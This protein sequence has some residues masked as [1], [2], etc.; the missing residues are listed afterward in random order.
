MY[1]RKEMLFYS[2]LAIGL[3]FVIMMMLGF[4]ELR[5]RRVWQ[6]KVSLIDD[7]DHR[8]KSNQRG[9]NSDG[10]RCNKDPDAFAPEHLNIIFLGDSFVY[11]PKVPTQYV[12]PQRFERMANAYCN[13]ALTVNVSNF[14]WTSS[15]PYLSL[16]QLKDIGSKYNPDIVFLCINMTD[17]HDDLKY[18]SLVERPKAIFKVVSWLPGSFFT[19]QNVFSRLTRHNPLERLYE[20]VFGL[21]N[22]RFFVVNK[23]LE[24]TRKYSQN[25][26]SNINKL[27]EF[28]TMKLGAKFILVI[29]P[30]SFQY[31]DRECLNSWEADQYEVFG[32]HVYEPFRF[33]DEL[34]EKVNYPIYSMLDDF[35]STTVFPTCFP[36]NPHWNARGHGIAARS[37]FAIAEKENIFRCA[38]SN[39]EDTAAKGIRHVRV[40][41]IEHYWWEAEDSDTILLPFVVDHDVNASGEKYIYSPNG[42]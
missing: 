24:Q 26:V 5:S 23:P 33:F 19:V 16:R 25:I 39:D 4:F 37:I 27:H 1:Y 31:S 2:I 9:N 29:L 7:I 11:G 41:T 32:P 22:D 40:K 21:P 35:R 8:M 18:Q 28:V 34:K 3:S 42:T 6:A 15:S 38:I 14:G 10:I 17:F 30:R 36:S 13:R 20:I 12:F